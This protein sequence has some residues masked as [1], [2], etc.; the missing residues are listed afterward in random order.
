MIRMLSQ[1]KKPIK[2]LQSFSVVQHCHH[3][4]LKSFIM[5]KKFI[6]SLIP[7]FVLV[8][9]MLGIIAWKL[10]KAKV[11]QVLR[12]L[13]GQI[14]LSVDILRYEKRYEYPQDYLCLTTYFIDDNWKLKKWILRFSQIWDGF[15]EL[16]HKIIMKSLKDWDI[17]EKISTITMLNDN[18]YRETCEIVKDHIQGKRELQLD[19]R[20][21]KVHCCG[22]IVSRMVQVA[23]KA[24]NNIIDNVRELCSSGKSLPLWY[25]TSAQLKDALELESGG[26]FFSQDVQDN[27]EVPSVEEWEKV[28]SICELA[29]SIYEVTEALFESKYPTANAYLYH[30]RELQAILIQKST[31][32]DLTESQVF[33]LF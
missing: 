29:D 3:R 14:S 27:Y 8:L 25:L 33:Q 30:L 6:T 19:G 23:Y 13:D 17:E 15:S 20:L 16:P 11:K 32:I 2:P 24:I 12:N 5:L 4:L 18:L 21:F 7:N 10:M 9:M 1:N 28:R 31:S 22:D 26:E